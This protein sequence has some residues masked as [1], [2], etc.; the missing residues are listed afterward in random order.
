MGDKQLA[1]GD[2]AKWSSTGAAIANYAAGPQ[3]G[4]WGIGIDSSAHVWIS[5]TTSNSVTELDSGG[6]LVSNYTVGGLSTPQGLAVDGLDNVW[7]ANFGAN[8][9]VT[10]LNNSGVALSPAKGF[11]GGGMAGPYHIAVDGS[12]NVWVSNNTTGSNSVTEIVGAAAPVVTPLA[13]AVKN[14]VLGTRP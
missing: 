7:V 8:T 2:V 10:E 3:S 14:N 4:S 5:D 6:T 12:G 11:T 9:S 13:L 1:T